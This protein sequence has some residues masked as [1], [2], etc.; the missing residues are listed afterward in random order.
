MTESRRLGHASCNNFF[1]QSSHLAVSL[2]LIQPTDVW[3]ITQVTRAKPPERVQRRGSG[4]EDWSAG[5]WPAG[6]CPARAKPPRSTGFARKSDLG[7][8]SHRVLWPCSRSAF[9]HTLNFQCVYTTTEVTV[10]IYMLKIKYMLKLARNQRF[11]C[12]V[13]PVLVGA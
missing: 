11:Q 9:K 8:A 3:W 7:A 12:F 10:A 6:S 1:T 4:S 2:C 13:G 5:S